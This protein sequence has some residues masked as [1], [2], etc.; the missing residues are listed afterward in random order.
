MG[1]NK[2]RDNIGH[3]KSARDRESLKKM[4]DVATT[5]LQ[6]GIQRQAACALQ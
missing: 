5:F 4:L 2:S 6:Q 3:L 1:L